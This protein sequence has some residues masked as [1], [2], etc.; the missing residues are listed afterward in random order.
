MTN[1]GSLAK[2]LADNAEAFCRHWFPSG[3]KTGN[4]WQ[5]GDTTG[6]GD[7]FN[8]ALAYGLAARLRGQPDLARKA[9]DMRRFAGHLRS[10]RL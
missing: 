8:G 9:D 4:Y 7:A 5:M 2:G 6:A 3:R 1:P 10:L